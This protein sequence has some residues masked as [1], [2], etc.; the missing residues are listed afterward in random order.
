MARGPGTPYRPT[1]CPHRRWARLLKLL[2]RSVSA[3]VLSPEGLYFDRVPS[4]PATNDGSARP[5]AEKPGTHQGSGEDVTPD[6]DGEHRATGVN[7]TSGVT[8]AGPPVGEALDD[9][10]PIPIVVIEP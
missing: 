10:E 8:G 4:P 6:D 2:R 9:T 1:T 7:V 5:L 3:C